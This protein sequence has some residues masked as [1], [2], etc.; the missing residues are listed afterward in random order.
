MSLESWLV[1]S[2]LSGRLRLPGPM[3]QTVVNV[4]LQWY[5]RLEP[6]IGR[7]T[8]FVPEETEEIATRSNELME[9]HYNM[10][11]AMF[12][13]FLDSAMKYSMGFWENG[14]RN[15]DD[16]QEDMLADLCAKAGIED[17]QR[18]LDIG[19]GFGSLAAHVLRRFPNCRV[20]G[21]TLSQTQADYMR[22]KQAEAGHPLNTDRFYLIQE[23]FNNAEFNERFDRIVSVGVFEH[24][25]NMTK[26]LE[27]IRTFIK[28]DGALFLHYI[29]YRPRPG[30]PDTARQDP[31]IDRYVFPG[32][33]IWSHTELA[34]HPQHFAIEQDWYLSGAN[35]KRTIQHWLANFS[36]NYRQIQAETGLDT[37]VLR[38]W[39]FYLRACI[40]T[41]NVARG[42]MYGNGQYRLRP[43]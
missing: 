19:C 14:A 16:A 10:P 36:R 24:I 27:R 9:M 39:A 37:R 5:H 33:R 38:V 30:T 31:F 17:G 13:G 34:K 8:S 21:L 32:G 26:A 25:S 43:I 11:L 28:D 40:G 29:V 20:Y 41:F 42:A 7:P 12:E 18:V 35:Y 15:L 23:D 22:A 1:D 3:V 4:Y 2:Y 6:L